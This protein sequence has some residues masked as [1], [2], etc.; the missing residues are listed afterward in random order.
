MDSV[1]AEAGHLLRRGGALSAWWAHPGGLAPPPRGVLDV[2]PHGFVPS[3]VPD[4]RGRVLDC[5][6]VLER[7]RHAG[8][9]RFEALGREVWPVADSGAWHDWETHAELG[10]PLGRGEHRQPIGLLV[11]LDVLA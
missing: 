2:E 11:T 3:L 9:R 4:T 7:T 6:L 1:G 10:A 5:S 8:D